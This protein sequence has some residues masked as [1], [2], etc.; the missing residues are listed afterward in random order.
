VTQN[1]VLVICNYLLSI[2]RKSTDS[3]YLRWDC[4]QKK[5]L[6]K[7]EQIENLLKMA[8]KLKKKD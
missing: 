4:L 7:V 8:E 6:E 1:D 5:E 3:K 2:K